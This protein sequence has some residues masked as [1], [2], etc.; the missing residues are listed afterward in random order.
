[1]NQLFKR[2]K[3]HGQSKQAIMLLL[4][5]S[6]LMVVLLFIFSAA[7]AKS[8]RPMPAK[9]QQ[10]S[11]AVSVVMVSPA[12]YTAQVVGYGEANPHYA[13][14]FTAQ[15]SGQVEHLNKRFESGEHV[16]KGELLMQL[17]NSAYVAAVANAESSV[18][19]AK[20]ALL[21]EKRQ[22]AQAKAEWQASGLK[23][24]PISAL[25]LR[26]PQLAVAK[27][28]LKQAEAALRNARI[29]L[30]RTKLRT[31]FDALVVT[32]DVSLG[33]Y[34]Q[35]GETVASL[36]STER[37]EVKID[38]SLKDWQNLPTTDLNGMADL[39]VK[40]LSVEG[41]QQWLGHVLRVEQHL[42][43]TTRQRALIVAVEQP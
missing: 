29:E 8:P 34:V 35:K 24:E 41:Q 10:Q 4:A 36:Y 23:G 3:R 12:E 18:A 40:L 43:G 7:D 33:A 16:K 2:V 9:P 13:L 20:L 5:L 25:V 21:E 38:L 32:R 27:A 30:N 39:P 14:D 42:D 6:I 19:N 1:M 15:V 11:L 22:V 28:T 31:P 37:A 17:E 26:Q